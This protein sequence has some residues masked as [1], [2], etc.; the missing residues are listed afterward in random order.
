[1]NRWNI[2]PQLEA[3]V[4]ARDTRCVYCGVDFRIP[5]SA[6]G[7]QPSWE[8]IINDARIVTSRN[9]ARCCISCN[10]SKGTKE[11]RVW[12]ESPYC[13]RKGISRDSVAQVVKKYLAETAA[14][15]HNYPKRTTATSPS[16][17]RRPL[18]AGDR[19]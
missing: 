15:P 1:M 10:A 9:I 7:S 8:H 18:R 2:T 19:P 3:E 6:R 4:L 5:V 13:K 17:F 11:L 14:Q 16:G 12:L